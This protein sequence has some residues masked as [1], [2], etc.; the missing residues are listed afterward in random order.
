MPFGFQGYPR[1]TQRDVRG[2]V[3]SLAGLVSKLALLLLQQPSV[4]LAVAGTA[5]GEL[6]FDENPYLLGL[7]R[8]LTLVSYEAFAI[9]VHVAPFLPW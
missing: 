8:T 9:L 6:A 3:E 2:P 1:R 4:A 7:P 5:I